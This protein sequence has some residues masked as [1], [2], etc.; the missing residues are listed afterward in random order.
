MAVDLEWCSTRVIG[1]MFAVLDPFP[2]MMA[3]M[4]MMGCF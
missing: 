1:S 3:A 2:P 4:L